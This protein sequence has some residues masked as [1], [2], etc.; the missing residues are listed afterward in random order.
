MSTIVRRADWILNVDRTPGAPAPIFEL[1]CTSCHD[2]SG[3]SET[4]DSPE[5]WALAHTGRH[6][7]HR[8]Y[9][10]LTTAFFRVSPAPGNPL[11]ADGA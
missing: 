9:R 6:P 3:A 7:Q 1:E 2:G 8:S 11:G 10:S 4:K 5:M